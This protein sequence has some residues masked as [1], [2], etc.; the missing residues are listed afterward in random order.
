MPSYQTEQM[1]TAVTEMVGD[2][3]QVAVVHGH[4]LNSDWWE[5]TPPVRG[6]EGPR[7]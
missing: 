1:L 7:F 5:Q 3:M 2:K 6:P 4:S